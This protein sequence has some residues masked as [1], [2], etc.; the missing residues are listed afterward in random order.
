TEKGICG[1]G[2]ASAASGRG[3]TATTITLGTFGDPGSPVT[4]G[5]GQEF[6]DVGEAFVAWCNEA[7]GINGREI[8]LNK[9][10]AKLTD[11]AARMIDACQTDFM[12]VGGGN[13]LDAAGVAPRVDCDLGSVPAYGVSPEAL[14]A[15]LQVRPQPNRADIYPVGGFRAMARMFPEAMDSLAVGGSALGTLR[16]NGLRLQQ[17]LTQLGD[18]VVSY[19]EMPA[20][21]TNYRPFVEQLK[22]SGAQG[23]QPI[24]IQDLSP[25]VTAM[26]DVG[27]SLS[28]M[29]IENQLYTPLTISAAKATTFPPTWLVL[30]HIPFELADES[31]VMRQATDIVRATVPDA[32][33]NNFTALSFSAWVLWAKAATACGDTLTVDCVLEKAGSET[34]WT[35]GGIFPAR[36]IVAGQQRTTD[37]VLLMKVTPDGFAY[38]KA[39]TAPNQGFFNC[40]P[41]NLEALTNTFS[42]ATG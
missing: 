37:C 34:A 39:A 17:A 36:N 1:P 35:A 28:F 40:D 27:L 2:D 24:G 30:D 7:G 9:H 32:D 12:S 19:Q 6:F 41:K 3:V 10:D 31:P 16:P 15:P 11:V 8:V 42:D 26:N 20:L 18:K 25:L 38:D 22:G 29:L 13:A 21:V 5:L 23:Y 14:D 4:P 33:L